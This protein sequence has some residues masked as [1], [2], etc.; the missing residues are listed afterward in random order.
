MKYWTGYITAGIIGAITWALMQLA[1]R[2]TALVDMVYPYI[3][4]TIMTFLADWSSS[5]DFCLWQVAVVAFAVVVIAS[6]VLMIM[7]K[8]NPIRWLG[9][10]LAVCSVV[11]FLNTAIF[12]L[13][14][15]AGSIAD[16]VRL[17]IKD[18]NAIQL[19]SSAEYYRDIANDLAV[20]VK[21]DDRGEVVFDD[22][23][24]LAEKAADGFDSLV[25]DSHFAIFAGST[26][27]VKELG[28]S[29]MSHGTHKLVNNSIN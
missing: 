16:D 4:R 15:Y 25:H 11:Y 7:M 14:Y 29:D 27:P 20:Q 22:F 24:T 6:I 1:E 3:S 2:Y 26:A 18:F 23:D 5:V 8:W 21:R 10:I 9:W 17:E 13:S 12:G 28:W 19:A